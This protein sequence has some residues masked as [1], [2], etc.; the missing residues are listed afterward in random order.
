VV[1]LNK[2][3]VAKMEKEVRVSETIA[4]CLGLIAGV[5]IFSANLLIFVAA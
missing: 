5:L 3:N 4:T 2:L 1:R